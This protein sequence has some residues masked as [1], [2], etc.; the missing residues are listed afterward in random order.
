VDHKAF[1]YCDAP[2]PHGYPVD[3][4]GCTS[5]ICEDCTSDKKRQCRK[6]KK[7]YC[8][9]D[10]SNKTFDEDEIKRCDHCSSFLC[11]GCEDPLSSSNASVVVDFLTKALSG[12]PDIDKLRKCDECNKAACPDCQL[13]FGKSVENLDCKGCVKMIVSALLEEKEMNK[14]LEDENKEL[15]NDNEDLQEELEWKNERLERNSAQITE[16][17]EEIYRLKNGIE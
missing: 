16:L 5:T 8:S 2:P 4:I 17:K 6:C 7:T 10:C 13:K 14:K 1:N 3:A 9:S 11:Y 15:K 12:R